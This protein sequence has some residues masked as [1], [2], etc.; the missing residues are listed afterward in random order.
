MTQRPRDPRPLAHRRHAGRALPFVLALACT[1]AL[2][3]CQST[4]ARDDA[5]RAQRSF[6][7]NSTQI[8]LDAS[9]AADLGYSVAWLTNVQLAPGQRIAHTAWLGDTVVVVER[10]RNFVSVLDAD[11]GELRWK[12]LVGDTLE[13]LF[14][15]TRLDD[16][17][18]VNSQTRIFQLSVR[19]GSTKLTTQ[20]AEVVNSGHTLLDGSAYF[21]S[22]NGVI[23]NHNAQSGALR[24]RYQLPGQFQHPPVVSPLLV[25][26][27]DSEGN[28]VML[29]SD[30]GKVRWR[31]KTFG[32][33]QARP[34]FG[35]GDVLVASRDQSLYSLARASGRTNWVYRTEAPLTEAPFVAGR[36]VFQVN[37]K[38]GLVALDAFT[39]EPK[40]TLEDDSLRAVTSLGR[41][42]LMLG[43]SGLALIDPT[44]GETDQVFDTDPLNSV[45]TSQPDDPPL[46]LITK[47]GRVCRLSPL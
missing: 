2:S 29:T 8:P 47:D 37:P 36:L 34:A 23:F 13:S 15:P 42:L 17:I 16:V 4:P 14:T 11:S 3:A 9:T 26:A 45:L 1:L 7:R 27:A 39:G 12:S 35:L 32:P 5:P 33:V 19:D 28:Y 22:V 10:P 38:E 46:I 43:D 31:N 21:A 44:T 24:W 18:L 25:F 6:D 41:D 40:F 30:K 20:L